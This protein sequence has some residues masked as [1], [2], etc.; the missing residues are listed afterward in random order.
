MSCKVTQ[1]PNSL[2]QPG[3]LSSMN[4]PINE[5]YNDLPS[6][7]WILRLHKNPYRERYV[8]CSSTCS[9]KE[10]SMTMT[11]LCLQSKRDYNHIVTKYI[12]VVTS[13]KCGY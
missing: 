3:S 9:A 1:L 2:S 12:H 7:Y 6:L 5:E 10:L 4:I 11:Q 13:I 8:A